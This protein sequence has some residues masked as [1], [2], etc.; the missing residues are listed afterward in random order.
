MLFSYDYKNNFYELH[1][2]RKQQH[3]VKKAY[4]NNTNGDFIY[5]IKKRKGARVIMKNLGHLFCIGQLAFD[6]WFP[7]QD[8]Q[9]TRNDPEFKA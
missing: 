1:F 9:P 4:E 8:P 3:K 6:S 2:R 5:I 7:R